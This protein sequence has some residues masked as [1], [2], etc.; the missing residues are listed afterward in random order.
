MPNEKFPAQGAPSNY[1]DLTLSEILEKGVNYINGQVAGVVIANT[2]LDNIYQGEIETGGRGCTQEFSTNTTGATITVVRPLPLP[3]EARQLGAVING[4]NFSSYIYEPGSDSYT[5]QITTVIDDQVDIPTAQL[6]MIDINLLSSY[7]KLISDKV[8]L[9]INAIKIAAALFAS[10]NAYNT[11]PEKAN[12]VAYDVDTDTLY[13]KLVEAAFKL[14][15][16]DPDNGVSMFPMETRIALIR[17]DAWAALLSQKGILGVGGAN[18]AYDILRRGGLNN[19]VTVRPL[20]DGFVGEVLGVPFHTVSDLVWLTAEKYLGLPKNALD[21][22]IAVFKSAHGN[23][24]GLAANNSVK[25]IDSPKGQGI[26][27]QP[28]YRM[29]AMTIMP[30]ANSILVDTDKF[31]NPY[32]LK[33][34][35]TEVAEWKMVAPSSRRTIV[36]NTVAG[37]AV[38]EFTAQATVV[39]SVAGVTPTLY[40]AWVV[41]ECH[42]LAEFISAYN[43]PAAVKGKIATVGTEETLSGVAS[44]NTV[45]FVYCD[46]DGTIAVDFNKRSA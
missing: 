36:P 3:I 9:N 29:G 4:G 21:G 40:C 24:F 32:D 44:G 8:T 20:Y 5:F 45:S 15:N 13:D 22:L 10:L 34:I 39:P 25:T 23:L 35:F 26:R 41:G 33:S 7:V 46:S 37:D 28:L 6:S 11:D 38:G 27:L 2:V 17:N 31:Q 14:N 16:G 43:A 19:D 12:V 18:Y 30:K 42:T 1:E